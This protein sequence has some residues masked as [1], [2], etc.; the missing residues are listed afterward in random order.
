MISALPAKPNHRCSIRDLSLKL[1]RMELIWNVHTGQSI[2]T[3]LLLKSLPFGLEG[4]GNIDIS[5]DHFAD[6]LPT[7]ASNGFVTVPASSDP[8][9]DR[10]NLRILY[11]RVHYPERQKLRGNST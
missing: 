9:Y 3:E 7:R 6:S 8:A 2:P 11:P 1:M 4:I 5:H 10:E